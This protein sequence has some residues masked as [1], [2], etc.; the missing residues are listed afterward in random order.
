MS[1]A[2]DFTLPAVREAHEPPEARGLG[3]DGVR[4]LVSRKDTREITHRVFRE[5]PAILAPGDLLVV[6]NSA[7]VAAAVRLDRL[8][9]HF[10]GELPTGEWLVELRRRT[11]GATEPYAGGAPG[12]WLPLPGQA[13]LRLVR[14]ETPRLWRAVLNRD[15]PS[16]LDRYGVPIRY[17]Y[18]ERDWPLGHYQTVFGIE[19]GSAEM[20]SAG[21]PFTADLVTALV[22]RGVGVAPITLHTG[23]AS[24]EKDEPPYPERFS[25]PAYTARLVNLTR[26][27]GGRVI[28]VGTTVVR[29]LESA[30]RA[31]ALKTS[32]VQNGTAQNNTAQ[33]NTGG[34]GTAQNDTVRAAE[35][36]TAHV[37]TPDE[38]VRAVDG[39]LTGLHEPRSSHL[40]MLSAIADPELLSRSYQA[41]LD[42][43]YLWH[44]FGDTHLIL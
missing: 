9:V 40:M 29:A 41:A 38:G 1:L 13:T 42:E 34:A 39:L 30:A 10:S 20:P 28:A 15:V 4:L 35:G 24:P 43:G 7:T 22:A 33:N 17:S 6:N 16:Y 44:E 32:P 26:Q 8:A 12:E 27:N 2:I 11:S 18:V 23:V 25:V 37:V 21:R 5:L 31:D 14:R 19:P 3:R 36:W